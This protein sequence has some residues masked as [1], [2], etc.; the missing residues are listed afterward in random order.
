MKPG[1]LAVCA[2]FYSCVALAGDQ[3]NGPVLTEVFAGRAFDGTVFVG[4]GYRDPICVGFASDKSDW[5]MELT[6]ST[7]VVRYGDKTVASGSVGGCGFPPSAIHQ[8]PSIQ[9][10]LSAAKYV[11]NVPISVEQVRLEFTEEICTSPS[12]P[13]DPIVSQRILA[14]VPLSPMPRTAA[15]LEAGVYKQRPGVGPL[16]SPGPNL[17]VREDRN[18]LS[19]VWIGAD[20]DGDADWVFAGGRVLDSAAALPAYSSA[21]GACG[22]CRPP[23]LQMVQLQETLDVWIRNVNEIWVTRPGAGPRPMEH[24]RP[25]SIRSESELN[26]LLTEP[27][28]GVRIDLGYALVSDLA[29]EWIDVDRVLAKADGRLVFRAIGGNISSFPE[30]RYEV[31]WDGGI[32][33]AIC[34][35]KGE[36]VV[37]D[38]SNGINVVFPISAVGAERVYSP[39]SPCRSAATCDGSFGGLFLIRAD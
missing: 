26:W 1:I 39:S 29:G 25:W 19:L 23:D 22:Y 5:A 15:R 33:H 27:I 12:G 28:S 9:V 13:C 16:G 37:R 14:E 6:D 35:P 18:A 30:L 8:S 3:D 36:C 17:Q 31:R 11:G 4:I 10:A 7:L 34:G 21:A 38:V 24:W 20:D 2:L 32:G